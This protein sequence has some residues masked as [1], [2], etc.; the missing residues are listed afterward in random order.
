MLWT[1]T[2]ACG[3]DVEPSSAAQAKIS[4]ALQAE[5]AEATGPVDFLVILQ[6]QP[7]AAALVAPAG[8]PEDDASPEA[9]RVAKLTQVYKTLTSQAIQ[10]QAGLRA[11]LDAQ[12]VDYR[13]F[14]L[15]NMIWVQGD[16]ALAAALAERP[17]V[18]RLV[19]NPR[20]D[21]PQ[22][23]EDV[24]VAAASPADTAV[25]YGI[26]YTHAPE[27]WAQGVRG[28][29]IVLA[30]QDTGAQ[31]D[32]PALRER[33]RGWQDGA[34]DHTYN[35]LN[36]WA[37]EGSFDVCYPS[38]TPCDD[39]GHGTH[40]VGTMVG[41]DEAMTYGMAPDAGW[42]A[43]RN[44]R[45]GFGT[46][47]TYT[48][49][50]EFFL[51]PYPQDGD[52][53]TDGRP[54]L[55]PHIINNSWGCPPDEGCDTDTLRQVVE[56][57]R[58]AGQLVV[59]SAGN[60]GP[61]CASV[62]DPI[63]I[64]DAAF[65]V[66]AHDQFGTIAG[67]SSVGPVTVDDSGRLK[68]DLVAPG[69]SVLSTYLFSETFTLSGT[70]MA[71]PHVAGAAALIWSAV[72]ELIGNPDLT[73]QLLIK[74]ATVV[75]NSYCTDSTTPTWPNPS[76]GYGRL[77]VAAALAMARQPW[78]VEVTVVDADGDPLAG[79]V[80]E[81]ED[82]ETG[83]LVQMQTSAD[84]VARLDLV[85]AGRYALRVQVGE[86]E[87]GVPAIELTSDVQDGERSNSTFSLRYHAEREGATEPPRRYF[88]PWLPVAS[89]DPAIIFVDQ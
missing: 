47:A 41:A 36:A 35:W 63:A 24:E 51:A 25:P 22:P 40:T 9:R 81:W 80:V 6:A 52:P 42:I 61:F 46:P 87:L 43:C 85:W 33:Y 14:Y 84:G 83:Y 59:S 31:W 76:Y 64:Y 67:F 66:G 2:P 77:D 30:S 34:A 50:F 86:E 19:T 62:E 20:V 38:D 5:L 17:E 29:G 16:P 73:E 48:A 60:S 70:S 28:Q 79:A 65:T 37:S 58:A 4:R 45:F 7:D 18:N 56:T 1:L 71:A 27:L 23:P 54:D 21:L 88:L 57:V 26:E 39:M 55:A 49:C 68:P 89:S 11:W 75:L 72:P 13:P 53:F 8:A 32:H 44:M 74:S 78:Q 69:V 3:Q 82:L 15:V 10:S 12:G